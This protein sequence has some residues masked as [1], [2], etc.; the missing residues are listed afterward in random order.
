MKVGSSLV[1]SVGNGDGKFE[2]S[3]L[4]DYLFGLEYL[5]GGGSSDVIAGGNVVV[6]L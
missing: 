4:G 2:G 1:I 6:K 5:T 3:P